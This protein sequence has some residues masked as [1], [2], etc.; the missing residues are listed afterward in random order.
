MSL[1]SSAAT[2]SVAVLLS[3]CTLPPTPP[4]ARVG[5]IGGLQTDPKDTSR[6]AIVQRV[7]V[8]PSA[9]AESCR[10]RVAMTFARPDGVPLPPPADAG[11]IDGGHA[12]DV[13]LG[14]G[15]L[16]VDCQ[17]AG[18]GWETRRIET[19]FDPDEH[20]SAVAG[21]ALGAALGGGLLGVLMTQDRMSGSENW[22]GFNYFTPVI[23]VVP[24]SLRAD[25]AAMATLRK[26]AASR[27]DQAA[28]AMKAQCDAG[29]P[30]IHIC[31]PQTIQALRAID[32]AYLAG[33]KAPAAPVPAP[34]APGS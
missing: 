29:K 27:W 4:P 10:L 12:Y 19:Y 15:A 11:P 2:L 30:A 3:A 34:G 32:E 13:T 1:Y 23:H 21:A 31:N 17:L 25:P 33:A 20:E 6:E 22:P 16:Q 14:R 5:E 7:G 8:Y 28:A 24:P 26:T 18:G 9:G